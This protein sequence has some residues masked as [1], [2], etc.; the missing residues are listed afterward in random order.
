MKIAP[1]HFTLCGLMQGKFLLAKVSSG[2]KI[3][4]L[5]A[6]KRDEIEKPVKYK[7][8]PIFDQIKQL[9][10]FTYFP[11]S[12]KISII[13]YNQKLFIMKPTPGGIINSSLAT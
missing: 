1:I 8:R 10:F 3:F 13:I 11:I 6:V 9:G 7:I 5:S 4:A 12:R 2:K